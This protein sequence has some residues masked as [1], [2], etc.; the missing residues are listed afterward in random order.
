MLCVEYNAKFRL[1][2]ELELPY[3]PAHTWAV[4]DYQGASLASILRRIADRYTLVCCNVSGVN[5][6]FVRNDL[7][8]SFT[9]YPAEALYQPP[10]YHLILIESGHAPTLKF[11]A[12]SLRAGE[13]PPGG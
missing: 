2:L 3:D 8:S 7:A 13:G 5:A 12:S 1:P 6:F 10:R 11:L 4:D 9:A